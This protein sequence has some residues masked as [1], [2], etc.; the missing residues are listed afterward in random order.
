[1]SASSQKIW[2][3]TI[4]F[5]T[6][7]QI[8]AAVGAYIPIGAVSPVPGPSAQNAAPGFTHPIRLLHTE[9]TTNVP[10]MYSWD[11]IN[12]HS[13]LIQNAFLLLDVCSNKSNQGSILEIPQGTIIYVRYIDSAPTSGYVYLSAFYAF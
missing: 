4:R 2:P 8:A 9:D 13:A 5:V 7:T 10:L 11:G 6:F 3:E 12:D 1:M